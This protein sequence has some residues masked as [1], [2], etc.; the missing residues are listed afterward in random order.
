MPVQLA[1]GSNRAFLI[2]QIFIHEEPNLSAED[3]LE[4]AS[5]VWPR[6]YDP[7]ATEA[8]LKRTINIVARAEGRL[9]AALRILT[10]GYFF[11]TVPEILVR[12]EWQRRGIGRALLTA[13]WERSPTGWY[14]GAQPGN[15]RFFEKCGFDRGLQSY[16]RRKPRGAG[17]GVADRT[18]N[19]T[20]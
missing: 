6:D 8:A 16:S 5:A 4:L 1:L 9:V 7:V 15:E 13:A 20:P 12:P 2:V 17:P 11:G 19:V 18:L 10:D 3:F 14:F